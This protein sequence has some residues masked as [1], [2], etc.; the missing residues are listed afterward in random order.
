[1]PSEA[2]A[3]PIIVGELSLDGTVCNVPGIILMAGNIARERPGTSFIVPLANLAEALLVPGIQARGGSRLVEVVSFLRGDSEI[4]AGSDCDEVKQ[5]ALNGI[6]VE[7]GPDFAEVSG[8]EQV[9]RAL[10]IAAA[11]PLAPTHSHLEPVP[12][13]PGRSWP[14]P[15]P[16]CST[17]RLPAQ[18]DTPEKTR[19]PR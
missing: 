9:K 17:P 7:T 5:R 4:A 11:H 19:S 2:A 12:V 15:A 16:A 10:E 6:E 1:V 3:G 14:W 13:R 8:Q 18:R